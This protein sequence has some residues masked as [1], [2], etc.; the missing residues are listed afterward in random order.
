MDES[1]LKKMAEITNGK[2]FN[3]KNSETFS[4]IYK[5]I[6]QL[7]K[8]EIKESKFNVYQ[9]YFPWIVQLILISI[10]LE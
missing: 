1:T 6:N 8:S 5:E 10:F 9:D 2:Y 7:E 4:S 3:V